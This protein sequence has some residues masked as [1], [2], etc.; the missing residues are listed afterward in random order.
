MGGDLMFRSANGAGPLQ[1]REDGRGKYQGQV[2][3]ASDGKKLIKIVSGST[4]FIVSYGVK[5]NTYRTNSTP[6]W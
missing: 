6:I 4:F 5:N 2:G 1:K 3:T